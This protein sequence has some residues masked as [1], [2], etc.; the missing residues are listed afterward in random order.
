MIRLP[1]RRTL[2]PLAIAVAV[3]AVQTE[4]EARGGRRGSIRHQGGGSGSY[5]R[6]YPR[7]GHSDVTQS[8]SGS[9]GSRSA[10]HYDRS[11]SY[12]GQT[13][14]SATRDGDNIRTSSETTGRHGGS[15]EVTRDV[16][17]DDGRVDK[18]TRESELTTRDGETVERQ[19]EVERK[20]GY[21]EFEGEAKT[22]WGR[23]ASVEGVSGRDAYGRRWTSA[24]VDTKYRGDVY[25]GRVAGPGGA[26]TVAVG[27]YGAAAVTRLPSGYRTV[28]YASRP[29]YYYGGAYYRPYYWYGNPYYWPMPPPYGVYYPYPP[30]GSVTIVLGTSTYQCHDHVFY[31]ETVSGT[32]VAY[33]VVPA[34]VGAKVPPLPV[35][36]ATI[37]GAD[38][39]F[40]YYANTFYRQIEADAA[41]VDV[42]GDGETEYIVVSPPSD[43]KIHAELPA[44]FEIIN[45]DEMSYF[46]LGDTFF[47]PFVDASENEVYIEVDSPLTRATSQATVAAPP[48]VGALEV[49]S[50]TELVIR[51]ADDVDAA[52]AVAGERFSG[53]LDADVTSDGRIALAR[54]SRVHGRVVAT[55]TGADSGNSRVVLQLTEVEAS[56]KTLTLS[57]GP[58]A[59]DVEAARALPQVGGGTGLG[60][61][62]GEPTAAAGTVGDTVEVH[63]Q[64]LLSFRLDRSLEIPLG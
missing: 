24:E 27:P 13:D 18:V 10:M 29:Y 2:L 56:T 25:V 63:A 32:E 31:E 54:G 35:T 50:G 62:V 49:A 43:L 46:R 26:R 15:R 9:S 44:E 57:T 6:S 60:A 53:Y 36:H 19:R 51:I 3:L 5:Q 52:T 20:D 45:H 7:G 30:T 1:E 28:T 17:M 40:H 21:V 41:S 37:T 23:E 42:G 34:P 59:L 8:R 22:S 47:L 61:V 14:R 16:E 33:E 39:T 58:I 4:S 38:L 11:G 64:T 48:A 55:S 12:A